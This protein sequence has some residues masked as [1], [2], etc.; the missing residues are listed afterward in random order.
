MLALFV[1]FAIGD[2]HIDASDSQCGAGERRAFIIL[3]LTPF[4]GIAV[5]FLVNWLV[6][7]RK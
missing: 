2:C 3:I 7:R 4:S 5:F 6:R 1:A